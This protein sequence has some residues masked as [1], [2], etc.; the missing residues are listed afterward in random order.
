MLAC[1]GRP[2]AASFRFDA[3]AE[4]PIIDQTSAPAALREPIRSVP[5]AG[6]RAKLEA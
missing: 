6:D 5:C 4:S 2:A 1:R 3:M